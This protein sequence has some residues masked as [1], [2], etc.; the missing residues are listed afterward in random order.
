MQNSKAPLAY[1]ELFLARLDGIFDTTTQHPL[2][3]YPNSR[4]NFVTHLVL[5]YVKMIHV[6]QRDDI[7]IL[8]V[9]ERN[10]DLVEEK[11]NIE[12]RRVFVQLVVHDDLKNG[13]LWN[14]HAYLSMSLTL[15]SPLTGF[16]MN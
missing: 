8:I 9:I 11:L 15:P 13:Q 3:T 4:L 1:S 7:S 10:T 2:T 5:S 14:S 12:L 16:I 6:Y